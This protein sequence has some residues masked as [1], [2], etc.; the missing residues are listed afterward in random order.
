M[1][2]G[3]RSAVERIAYKREAMQYK[4]GMVAKSFLNYGLMEMRM[5][6]IQEQR[7]NEQDL[8]RHREGLGNLPSI[9]QKRIDNAERDFKGKVSEAKKTY[10]E[11]KKT[12]F[13]EYDKAEGGL[14]SLKGIGASFIEEKLRREVDGEEFLALSDAAELL[15]NK[16]DFALAEKAS[17]MSDATKW[18]NSTQKRI[19]S[20]YHKN[21]KLLQKLI[22]R[23]SS[24]AGQFSLAGKEANAFYLNAIAAVPEDREDDVERAEVKNQELDDLLETFRHLGINVKIGENRKEVNQNLVMADSLFYFVN[25]AMRH[26]VV[27]GSEERL[28]AHLL[29]SAVLSLAGEAV[30]I[31]SKRKIEDALTNTGIN[32]YVTSLYKIILSAQGNYE[33]ARSYQIMPDPTVDDA[34]EK[35]LRDT[36]LNYIAMRMSGELD[37]PNSIQPDL[38]Q[39][40]AIFKGAQKHS[41]LSIGEMALWNIADVLNGRVPSV[42]PAH[43]YNEVLAKIEPDFATFENA[44]LAAMFF[45]LN[46]GVS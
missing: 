16:I 8:S 33:K 21:K 28:K 25:G 7:R 39:Y 38:Y 24:V 42:E 23:E 32:I 13:Y 43:I 31:P 10:E 26:L 1:D 15:R 35:L 18:L 40:D 30:E 34:N 11:K 37:Q 5:R 36:C 3:I 6:L 17:K 45:Y 41:A 44:A 4:R 22:D 27:K 19:Q 9:I 2:E 20:E 12:A 46:A 14:K 29:L